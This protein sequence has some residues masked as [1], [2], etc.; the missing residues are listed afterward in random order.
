MLKMGIPSFGESDFLKNTENNS[1][2]V[3][4][5][6]SADTESFSKYCGML[7]DNGFEKKEDGCRNGNAYAAYTDGETAVF[8]NLFAALGELYIVEEKACRYFSYFDIS[9]DTSAV[10]Q[11]TQLGLEDYGIVLRCPPF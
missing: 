6:K 3:T 5:I 8:L 10:P 9:K 4:V 7:S 2:T 11:I 1:S